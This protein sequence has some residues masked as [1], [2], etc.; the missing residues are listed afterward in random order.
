MHG[1]L[2][3][4]G[5]SIIVATIVGIIAHRIKQPIILGYLLAGVIIGPEIGPQLVTDPANIEIISEIGLILLLFIIGLEMNPQKVLSSG[6]QILLSGIGQFLLCVLLGVGFFILVG[7]KLTGESLDAL[8]LAVF[9]ALSSTAIVVKLLYDKFELDT[10]PGRVTLGILIFQDVWAILVLAI[11]PNFMD[12]QIVPV[13]LAILKSLLLLGVGFMVS[14]YILRRLFEWI[15]KS[16]EIV[17]AISIGWC[18][19]LA[20][21]AHSIGLSKEMGAL[22][23]GV[24]I[25][26]FPYS[27]HVTA[28]VLPLRDFFLTLFFGSPGGK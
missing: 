3:D 19:I 25:S 28:K 21:A 9:C 17:V 22:I 27:I 6:K 5:I 15:A 26:T 14:K 1:F 7:Y 13:G 20:G 23:A 16:P 4:I 11:Q 24:S 18:A 10:L 12:P 2:E 8:Y